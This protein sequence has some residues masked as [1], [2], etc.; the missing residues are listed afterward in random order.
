MILSFVVILIA[1]LVAYIWSSRGFYNALV[2]MLCTIIAGAIAFAAWEP[3]SYF[4]L[5]AMGKGSMGTIMEAA[6]WGLG[7]ALPFGISLGILRA[8][9]DS[10]LRA[11]ILVSTAT[12]Y[13]G[14]GVCGLIIGTITAGILVISISNLRIATEFMG[15]QPYRYDNSGNLVRKDTLIFPADEITGKL[16]GALSERAFASADPLARWHPDVAQEGHAMRVS[17][18]DGAARNT[19]RP[20]E[21]SLVKQFSVKGD[22]N[23]LLSD[24]W[25]GTPQKATDAQGRAFE[26]GSRVEGFVLK[27]GPS[28]GEKSGKVILGAGQVRLLVADANDEERQMLFPVA[29]S[30][31][32]EMPPPP[33]E[34]SGAAL[35]AYQRPTFARWRYDAREVFISSVGGGADTFFGFEFVVPQKFN[36]VAIYV[37]GTRI[38]LSGKAADMAFASSA[39]RDQAILNLA[40]FVTGSIGIDASQIDTAQVVQAKRDAQGNAVPGIRVGEY[41]GWTIQLGLHSPLDIDDA[42]DSKVRNMVRGGEVTWGKQDVMKMRT[43]GMEKPLRVEKFVVEPDVQLVHVTVS[44]ADFRTSPASFLG[45]VASQQDRTLPPLLVD[46][47]G[48]SYPVIGYQYEDEV[49]ATLRYTPDRPIGT[50]EEL[51]SITRSRAGEQQMTLIFRVSKGVSIK[52]FTIGS[53][54]IV[55]Y[56]PPVDAK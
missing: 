8:I 50:I 34:L 49:K 55:E 29:V 15:Y 56:V 16:Y 18:N 17:Y 22:L 5:S 52:Y 46:S 1:G 43:G 31:Q 7:L 21:V 6:A 41:I 11:N 33:P 4:L 35:A 19:I 26:P 23:T 25:S 44:G 53:K 20:N 9:A 30:S 47:N 48:Q 27:F 3:A 28:A 51:P 24:L 14:G 40:G 45:P 12:N 2:H 32:A 10:I 39:Q 36:P 54:A 37:R 13:I 38:D 42:E